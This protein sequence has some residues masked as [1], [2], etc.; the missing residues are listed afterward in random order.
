MCLGYS[1][2]KGIAHD[3]GSTAKQVIHDRS[4]IEEK[5]KTINDID[6]N[7]ED[8]MDDIMHFPKKEGI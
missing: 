5:K 1:E 7:D 6:N 4:T 8:D 2:K 3:A